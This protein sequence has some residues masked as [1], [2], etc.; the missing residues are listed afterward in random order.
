MDDKVQCACDHCECMVE[1]ADAIVKDGQYYCDES[2]ANGHVDK[3]SCGHADCNC[4]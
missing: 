2:C 3:S 4:S 1:P